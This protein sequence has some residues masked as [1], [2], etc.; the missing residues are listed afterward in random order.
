MINIF[1]KNLKCY[2]KKT[3]TSY[4]ILTLDLE[5]KEVK[6][7]KTKVTDGMTGVIN[8]IDEVFPSEDV[9]LLL[10]TGKLDDFER[11]ILEGDLVLFGEHMDNK[12]VVEWNQEKLTFI[13]KPIDIASKSIGVFPKSYYLLSEVDSKFL[14]I[15]GNKLGVYRYDAISQGN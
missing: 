10:Y 6:V 14:H 8:H 1:D 13:I 7:V 12:G 15:I 4:Q 2:N 9:E 5:K 3:Q 11:D